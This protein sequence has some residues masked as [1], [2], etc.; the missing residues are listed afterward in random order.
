MSAF[1]S[2]LP[3]Y[4]IRKTSVRSDGKDTAALLDAVAARL[5]SSVRTNRDDGVKFDFDDGWVH[6][7]R[8]NTEP[9]V[10]VIAEARTAREAEALL[11]R[12][13]NELG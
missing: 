6:L 11:T 2:S 10:R 12:F 13:R 9:I 1:R 3:E 7:R 4:V 8:S 5:S